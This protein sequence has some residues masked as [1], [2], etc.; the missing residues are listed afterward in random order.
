MPRKRRAALQVDEALVRRARRVLKTNSNAAAVTR[1]LEEV[2]ANREIEAALTK[3]LRQGRG[4][5][6]DVYEDAQ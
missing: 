6:L 3:L 2:V 5:F 4:R 1:A